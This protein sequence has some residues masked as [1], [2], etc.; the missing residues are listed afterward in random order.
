MACKAC[1]KISVLIGI[2]LLYLLF[3]YTCDSCVH[4]LT[5]ASCATCFLVAPYLGPACAS[6][7][8]LSLIKGVL[9]GAGPLHFNIRWDV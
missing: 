1:L 5:A 9:V 2:M 7:V 4:W 6:G 3:W 8:V